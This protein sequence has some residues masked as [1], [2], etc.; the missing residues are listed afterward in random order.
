MQGL[1]Q[2]NAKQ[3]AL[4]GITTEEHALAAPG[5]LV[6]GETR[7]ALHGHSFELS[8]HTAAGWDVHL[9]PP[10]HESYQGAHVTPE[11]GFLRWRVCTERNTLRGQVGIEEHGGALLHHPI[12]LN[13]DVCVL[14][15][16][17]MDGKGQEKNLMTFWQAHLYEG[18]H[19]LFGN[20]FEHDGPRVKVTA[21][22]GMEAS[23]LLEGQSIAAIQTPIPDREI[24]VTVAGSTI[25]VPVPGNAEVTLATL[26]AGRVSGQVRVRW[27]GQVRTVSQR[28]LWNEIVTGD[29]V[30]V[31]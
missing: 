24:A 21:P 2:E 14:E 10:G 3:L 19:D 13:P 28:A 17:I 5:W 1:T 23:F 22:D 26:L 31:L 16:R 15:L 12:H 29:T 9:G 6:G 4:H 27:D 25:S 8:P 18:G 30:T 20:R 11:D 7:A